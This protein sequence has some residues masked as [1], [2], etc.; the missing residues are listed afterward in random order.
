MESYR[1]PAELVACKI[2]GDGGH[3]T[4]DCPLAGNVAAAGA[5][6]EEMNSEYS[7]FL[8]EI[9]VVRMSSIN[10]PEVRRDR[11]ASARL[12][13]ARKP[14]L[15][16]RTTTC[17]REIGSASRAAIQTTPR[18]KCASDVTNLDR[19]AP[20]VRD[21]LPTSTGRRLPSAKLWQWSAGVSP[22]AGAASPRAAAA[23]A[24]SGRHAS[25]RRA[26]DARGGERAP[27]SS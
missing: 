5:A 12:T 27:S 17:D 13:R 20:A 25:A 7:A 1:A 6:K 8:N 4:R 22:T 9:G 21:H 18:D 23:A 11:P 15:G 3:P 10:A 26:R 19:R 24:D 2:C 14:D 16:E